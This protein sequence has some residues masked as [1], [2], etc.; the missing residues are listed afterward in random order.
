MKV[1]VSSDDGATWQKTVL[2]KLQDGRY[3]ATY[4]HPRTGDFISLKVLSSDTDGNAVDQT[5]IHAY[6]LR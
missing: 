6:R 5:L 1:L 4:T 2:S 3:R